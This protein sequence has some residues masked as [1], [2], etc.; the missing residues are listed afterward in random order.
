[1]PEAASSSSGF[2]LKDQSVHTLIFKKPQ[3][4][5]LCVGVEVI[6][7][8]WE[9]RNGAPDRD[10]L[11]TKAVRVVPATHGVTGRYKLTII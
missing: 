1:M 4:G 8:H 11:S 6:C 10:V 7:L 3:W 9:S 2:G 5:P